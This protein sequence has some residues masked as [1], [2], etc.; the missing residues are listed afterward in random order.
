LVKVKIQKTK[1]LKAMQRIRAPSGEESLVVTR[2]ARKTSRDRKK[3]GRITKTEPTGIW[4]SRTHEK[5][6][7][8]EIRWGE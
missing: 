5:G 3:T 1:T 7:N 4:K 2:H 6:K 8:G